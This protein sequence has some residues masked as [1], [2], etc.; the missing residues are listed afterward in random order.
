MFGQELR[1]L[2]RVMRRSGGP[3]PERY[4]SQVGEV[5][6]RF[7][8]DRREFVDGS[9]AMRD[10]REKLVPATSVVMATRIVGYSSMSFE[11]ATA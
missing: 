11:I 2:E 7:L 5:S 8:E 3:E 10:A 4:S 6:A 1:D 9:P